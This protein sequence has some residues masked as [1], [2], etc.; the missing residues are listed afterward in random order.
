MLL[1]KQGLS[2]QQPCEALLASLPAIPALPPF[3]SMI[4]CKWLYLWASVCVLI[5]KMRGQDQMRW[6]GSPPS[7]LRCSATTAVI[8]RLGAR[9]C[10]RVNTGRRLCPFF[11]RLPSWLGVARDNLSLNAIL[12]GSVRS[13]PPLFQL[14]LSLSMPKGYPTGLAASVQILALSTPV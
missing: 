10:V 8:Q 3:T 2:L 14:P 5:C 12:Q 6:R 9:Q 4:F 1:A 11:G 7:A 13:S